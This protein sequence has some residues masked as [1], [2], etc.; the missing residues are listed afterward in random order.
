MTL[1]CCLP[2][3][4][5][6]GVWNDADAESHATGGKG[7]TAGTAGRGGR[8]SWPEVVLVRKVYK[9]RLGR[10]DVADPAEEAPRT[11]IPGGRRARL[12][13]AAA[14]AAAVAD[15]EMGAAG[16][17]A[18]GKPAPDADAAGAA[19][20]GAAAPA[21]KRAPRVWKLKR[22]AELVP[23][24]GEGGSGAGR[25]AADAA[26]REAADFESFLQARRMGGEE[27]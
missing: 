6:A 27:E 25:R 4:H 9:K 5:Q 24:G 10:D 14:T 17:A 20:S 3:H 21:R 12:A 1:P 13:A 7:R 19:A 23:T 8:V 18:G 15:D 11:T 16:A 22:L 26:A 2:P